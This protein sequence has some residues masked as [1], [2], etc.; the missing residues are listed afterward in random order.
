[1]PD[2]TTLCKNCG[3]E[4]MPITAEITG[5]LCMPCKGGRRPQVRGT[6]HDVE[7]GRRLDLQCIGIVRDAENPDF[8]DYF[9]EADVWDKDPRFRSRWMVVGVNRGL[10]RLH[11]NSGSVELLQPMPEDDGDQRFG[12][13]SSRIMKHWE[14][15]EVPEKT[16]FA[17][18]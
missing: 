14:L 10:M 17:S 16:M 6:Y 2:S 4:I 11:K 1:M 12:R 9:F 13:A 3:T 5:G 15:G 8:E 18:G 7:P